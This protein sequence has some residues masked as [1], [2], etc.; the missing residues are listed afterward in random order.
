M[1]EY[2]T[3]HAQINEGAT[4]YHFGNEILSDVAVAKASEVCPEGNDG[5]P[6]C[7]T[8]SKYGYVTNGRGRLIEYFSAVV[9]PAETNKDTPMY[10][11]LF[12]KALSC[13]MNPKQITP[14]GAPILIGV[15]ELEIV[16]NVSSRFLL[17][18]R[19]MFLK[20][21]ISRFWEISEEQKETKKRKK[22]NFFIN[23]LYKY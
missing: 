22:K 10:I 15:I 6:A 9:M 7:V 3:E 19:L 5:L 14:T 20:I 12:F 1:R 23:I 16:L 8:F 13:L 21:S 18:C 4:T 17:R 2:P 11:P